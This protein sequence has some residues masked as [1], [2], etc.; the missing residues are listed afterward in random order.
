MGFGHFWDFGE[1]RVVT[2]EIREFW[3]SKIRLIP[4]IFRGLEAKK[5]VK[6]IQILGKKGARNVQ[7]SA[8]KVNFS[9]ENEENQLLHEVPRRRIWVINTFTFGIDLPHLGNNLHGLDTR[10][11]S[12]GCDIIL[13]CPCRP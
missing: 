6:K 9:V 12:H 5:W 11:I 4:F 1:R 13:S 3:R 8:G 7:K 10:V 2:C